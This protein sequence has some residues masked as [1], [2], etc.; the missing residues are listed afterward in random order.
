M[1]EESLVQRVLYLRQVE[2]LSQQQIADALGIGRKRVRKM[3]GNTINL[4]GC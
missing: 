4:R 2:R 1:L 3:L